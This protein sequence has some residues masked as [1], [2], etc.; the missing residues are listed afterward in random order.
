MLR[1]RFA[2][3]LAV[4]SALALVAAPAAF[5]H[6]AFVP[7]EAPA[8]SFARL[9]LSVPNERD[10]ASTVRVAVE[11]PESIRF[12]RVPPTPGW[13]VKVER[14]P[15]DEPLLVGNRRV[16]DRI[17]VVEWS[18]GEITGSGSQSFAIRLALPRAAGRAIA[19]R[20]TQTYSSGEV[21][22]WV[23]EPGSDTPAPRLTVTAF[24]PSAES[25]AIRPAPPPPPPPQ[26][27]A[28]TEETTTEAEEEPPDEEPD[29]APAPASDD[30]DGGVSTPLLVAL[31][32]GIAA[33]L[34]LAAWLVAARRRRP[35][36]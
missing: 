32:L 35:S 34:A 14:E 6:F 21:V 23:G 22:E 18:G 7:G 13:Q 19:F 26:P 12:V 27:P 9:Q 11:I 2:P 25:L 3:L 5:A 15:L 30:D 20:A 33:A 16:E 4:A 10:D 24:D 1:R 8:R 36:S 29:A 31:V 28:T 17:S